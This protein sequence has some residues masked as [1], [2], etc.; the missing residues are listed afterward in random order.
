MSES[1]S[2][3]TAVLDPTLTKFDQRVLA[4]LDQWTTDRSTP[5]T[6]LDWRNVWQVSERLREYD[7]A[8]VRRVLDGLVQL[9]YATAGGWDHRR[10][11]VATPWRREIAEDQTQRRSGEAS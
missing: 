7:V 11:W 3:D 4:A 2:N 10:V 9:G 5:D 1:P 6:P 8:M